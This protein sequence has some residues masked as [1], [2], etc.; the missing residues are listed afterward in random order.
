MLGQKLERGR[1]Q[2]R[3]SKVAQTDRRFMNAAMSS[4]GFTLIHRIKQRGIIDQSQSETENDLGRNQY[5]QIRRQ[6]NNRKGRH[7][8]KVSCEQP[9]K[10]IVPPVPQPK[11]K[12]GAQSGKTPNRAIK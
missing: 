6:N 3:S 4:F 8:P 9:A 2:R 5:C 7:Q 10:S 11:Y 1:P 12:K